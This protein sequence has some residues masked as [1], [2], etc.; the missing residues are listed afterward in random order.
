[1][2]LVHSSIILNG[3]ENEPSADRNFD[4]R[5]E[6]S[7]AWVILSLAWLVYNPSQRHHV[8]HNVGLRMDQENRAG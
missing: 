1:M 4:T 5:S 7:R 2:N 8:A 6:P 3:I